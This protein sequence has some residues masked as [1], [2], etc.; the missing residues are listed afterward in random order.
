LP[1]VALAVLPVVAPA[2]LPVV[3]NGEEPSTIFV[4]DLE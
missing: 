4:M 3:L 1:A 2:V